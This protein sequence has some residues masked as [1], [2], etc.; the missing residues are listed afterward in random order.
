[1]LIAKA[2][3]AFLGRT[4]YSSYLGQ[5]AVNLRKWL[6]FNVRAFIIA[7]ERY[8]NV[9]EHIF[10]SGDA[11]LLGVLNGIVDA[12]SGERGFMGVH[13]CTWFHLW[14]TLIVRQ[15][16]WISRD[17]SKDRPIRNEQWCGLSKQRGTSLGKDS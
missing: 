10:K 7:I 4:E 8:H 12:Y 1:M 14:R 3:D 17:Y 2:L 9:P 6:P 13:R 5:D 11:R 15:S 16:L